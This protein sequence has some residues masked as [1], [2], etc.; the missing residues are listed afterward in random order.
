MSTGI[1]SQYVGIFYAVFGKIIRIDSSLLVY[2]NIIEIV[3]T[4]I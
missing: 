3:K 1:T 4:V 2:D